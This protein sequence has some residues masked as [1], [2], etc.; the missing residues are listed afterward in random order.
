MQRLTQP[1][2]TWLRKH[3]APP[4][5]SSS[6]VLYTS[7]VVEALG[8]PEKPPEG[9]AAGIGC[10]CGI[11]AAAA[12]A[13]AAASFLPSGTLPLTTAPG[14]VHVQAGGAWASNVASCG[15]VAWRSSGWSGRCSSV[16]PG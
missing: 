2:V 14:R 12:A 10:S 16:A 3:R 15:A 9:R 6:S 7:D 1:L 5:Y 4:S 13:T 8:S 11:S